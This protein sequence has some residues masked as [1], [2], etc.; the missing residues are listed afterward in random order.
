M[1]SPFGN[2]PT[3]VL[4]DATERLVASMGESEL[5][6]AFSR[7]ISTMPVD[8]RSALVE[9]LFEAFRDR[10]ESSEDAAEDSGTTL[11]GITRGDNDAL[12]A[13]LAFAGENAGLLREAVACFVA[14]HPDLV[15]ALPSVIRSGIAQRVEGALP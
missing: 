7:R 12:A 3:D 13:L 14:G 5:N 1:M 4:V 11:E 2:V 9:A 8:G 15:D 10:G 6:A